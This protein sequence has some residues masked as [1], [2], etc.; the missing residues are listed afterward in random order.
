MIHLVHRDSLSLSHSVS[1]QFT[2]YWDE[3]QVDYI[4]EAYR[5]MRFYNETRKHVIH[6]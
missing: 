5:I 2:I 1:I 6:W 4:A 3:C